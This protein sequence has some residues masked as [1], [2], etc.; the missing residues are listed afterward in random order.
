MPVWGQG[1]ISVKDACLGTGLNFCEGCLSGDMVWDGQGLISVKDSCLGTRSVE[2][3]DRLN[4][5]KDACL[6]IG[7]NFCEGCP[8]RDRTYLLRGMPPRC[9]IF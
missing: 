2:S 7:L 1:L 6:G 9:M 4:S 5:V 3:G 8:L